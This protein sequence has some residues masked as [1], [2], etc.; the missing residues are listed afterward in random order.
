MAD[1]YELIEQPDLE[2]PV[3]VLALE[4]WIDAGLGAG[5]AREAL[6]GQLD[7]TTVA[8]FD[9]DQLLDY[10][11]RRPTMHLEEGIVTRLTW[12]SIE[13]RAASDAD[14]ND[15]LL[16]VG[17]EPDHRWP[18]FVRSVAGL[19]LDT[20]AR[21]AVG[22]GAYPAAV[23]HTRPS[24]LAAAAS[25]PELTHR[26]GYVLASIEAPAGVQ[27]GIERRLAEL[28]V[29]AVGLWAQVPHY[30]SA[31]PYP[32]AGAALV[33]GLAELGSLELDTTTLHRHG[34]E[35]RRRLDEL[36][37]ANPEHLG[38]LH[39]LEAQWDE[40]ASGAAPGGQFGALDASTL[41]SADE[42]AAEVERYLREQ[43]RGP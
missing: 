4:G 27:A 43:G 11:A 5:R 20:G 41:P 12:P 36:L 23:P 10:R 13:L 17:V 24:R 39:Q 30:A 8:V 32:S 31:M 28:G 42:L 29:P 21:L 18:A 16:L 35:V 2:A 22:L 19:L 33:D 7:T 25:T 37:A 14:G 9:S 38:M 40:A 6:L 1:L 26:A 34:E 3:V 15:L